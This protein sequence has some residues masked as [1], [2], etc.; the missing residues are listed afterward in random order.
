MPSEVGEDEE[1]ISLNESP[2]VPTKRGDDEE[3]ALEEG[4]GEEVEVKR[5]RGW[6]VS[7]PSRAEELES[8][9][10]LEGVGT[11][12]DEGSTLLVEIKR[13]E[14]GE[15]MEF[16]VFEGARGIGAAVWIVTISWVDGGVTKEVEVEMGKR[17]AAAD[18][19][20]ADS[21]VVIFCG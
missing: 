5:V 2:P 6:N 3:R 16:G 9:W 21:E 15:W 1:G 20:V 12:A 13:V 18:G 14:V 19:N 10:R 7:G 11:L 4:M 17:G 8:C